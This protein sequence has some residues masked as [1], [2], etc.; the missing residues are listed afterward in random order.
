MEN[1]DKKSKQLGISL[2]QDEALARRQ[3]GS[4][5][6]H[7]VPLFRVAGIV[8]G[9]WSLWAAQ[10]FLPRVPQDVR[11]RCQDIFRMDVAAWDGGRISGTTQQIVAF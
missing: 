11:V 2:K 3:N 7:Q 5:D 8:K 1:Q 10:H 6:T 4:T 9:K